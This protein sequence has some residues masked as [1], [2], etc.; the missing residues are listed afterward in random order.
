MNGALRADRP[1]KE[2]NSGYVGTDTD[3]LV[4]LDRDHGIK[5]NPTAANGNV[6][7]DPLISERHMQC[8]RLPR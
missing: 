7:M 1:F 5:D 3:G 4:H 6:N 2:A 8:T